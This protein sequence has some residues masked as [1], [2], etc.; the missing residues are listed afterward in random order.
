MGLTVLETFL[1][2]EKSEF[3]SLFMRRELGAACLVAAVQPCL[4][5]RGQENAEK[6]ESSL[7]PQPLAEGHRVGALRNPSDPKTQK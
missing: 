4:V 3:C 5:T 6:R 2:S 7:K 1:P